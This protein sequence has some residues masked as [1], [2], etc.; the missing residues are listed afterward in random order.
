ML[1]TMVKLLAKLT[2]HLGITWLKHLSG[3]LALEVTF[4]KSLKEGGLTN[5]LL[6]AIIYNG[7]VEKR[8]FPASA[9]V[10][11][12]GPWFCGGA[13]RRPMKGHNMVSRADM[14]KYR[15][16]KAPRL[17]VA[18]GDYVRIDSNHFPAR[19]FPDKAKRDALRETHGTI[20]D[21][22]R[23]TKPPYITWATLTPTTGPYAGT[24]MVYRAKGTDFYVIPRPKPKL[25]AS[26]DESLKKAEAALAKSQA[27]LAKTEAM[28][29]RLRSQVT[30]KR[31]RR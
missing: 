20:T 25:V 8:T 13:P 6:C 19:R 21:V 28:V 22:V 15:D 29:E 10:A 12:L 9:L 24:G 11:P 23:D 3:Q 31:L 16:K 27:R 7:R 2:S 4:P 17:P 30:T 14:T 26:P 1:R 18:V 5:C